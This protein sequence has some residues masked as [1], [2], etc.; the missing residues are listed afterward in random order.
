MT[1]PLRRT[2]VVSEALLA[3]AG[4]AGAVQLVAG[5]ATPP[6]ADLPPGLATWRLPGA[7]LFGTVAV[8]AGVAATLAFRRSP[9]APTAVVAG[10]ALLGVEL[11][12][13]I[14][15]VGP[16]RLQAVFGGVAAALGAAGIYARRAGWPS[17][18]SA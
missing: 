12:V 8:P 14:P 7:W 5:V 6:A 4:A 18:G 2:L 9:H 17:S 16:N 15:F 3:V 13:Q 11:V 1:Y 10:A